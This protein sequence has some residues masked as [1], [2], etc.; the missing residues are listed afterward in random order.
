MY[1]LIKIAF[2]LFGTI[3]KKDLAVYQD[4]WGQNLSFKNKTVGGWCGDVEKYLIQSPLL[5]LYITRQTI[6]LVNM[7]FATTV[8][9]ENEII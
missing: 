6:F 7:V 3:W 9:L 5:A 1:N 2:Q 4:L 8:T